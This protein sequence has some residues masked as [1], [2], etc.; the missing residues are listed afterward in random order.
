MRQRKRRALTSLE[1]KS[2]S[3]LQAEQEASRCPLEAEQEETLSPIQ[4][5][6]EKILGS[7]THRSTDRVHG[8]LT[9]C[10]S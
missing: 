1:E 5:T 7:V 6:H 9:E 8:V 3:P 2:F 10:R 4:S